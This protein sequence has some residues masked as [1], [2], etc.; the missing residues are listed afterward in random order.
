MTSKL[1]NLIDIASGEI[2]IHE[3]GQNFVKYNDWY[4]GQGVGG[5]DYPWCVVF[6]G[7]CFN[8]NGMDFPKT[9]HCK[10]IREHAVNSGKWVTSNY[11]VGDVFILP[12]DTHT[13]LI[14]GVGENGYLTTIEGNYQD[15]VSRVFRRS[16]EFLGAYRP[17]YGDDVVED[18]EIVDEQETPDDSNVILIVMP[19]DQREIE[20]L[21]YA[22]H[23]HGYE[24][25]NSRKQNGD[26]DGEVGPGTVNAATDCAMDHGL[27]S[28]KELWGWLGGTFIQEA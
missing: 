2:G 21:Q 23:A 7:W 13:G 25:A 9:A 20:S 18:P 4:W 27:H 3:V 10:G 19:T 24:P 26:F 28:Y 16:S 1:K 12:G 17:D 6:V 22:L 8:K 14:V 11:Q 5:S 15:Q